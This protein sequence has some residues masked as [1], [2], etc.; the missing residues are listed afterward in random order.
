MYVAHSLVVLKFFSQKDSNVT[1]YP[2]ACKKKFLSNDQWKLVVKHIGDALQPVHTK[3]YLNNDKKVNN[4]VLEDKSR[5]F[6]PMI[7][8]FRKLMHQ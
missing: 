2:A 8:D 1:I 6:K 5:H 4:V 7:I 3:G